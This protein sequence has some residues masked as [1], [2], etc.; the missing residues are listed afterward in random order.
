MAIKGRAMTP[1][2]SPPCDYAVEGQS[3]RSIIGSHETLIRSALHP[4]PGRMALLTF[5]KC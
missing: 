5:R 3:G 2:Q 4:F 1:L